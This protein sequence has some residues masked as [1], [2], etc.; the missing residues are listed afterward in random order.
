ML[1]VVVFVEVSVVVL[2]LCAVRL[3][4]LDS[5]I[6]GSPFGCCAKNRLLLAD[7]S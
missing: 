6:C 3:E 4:E 5:I 2:V 1:G 7:S